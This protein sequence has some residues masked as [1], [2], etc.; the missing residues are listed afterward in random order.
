M[1]RWAG[2]A[3]FG[4]IGDNLVAGAPLYILKKLGYMTEM[5]TSE[6]N[7]VVFINN[8]HID[9]LSVH[10]TEKDLPQNDMLA[11]QKWFAGRERTFDLFAHLSHSMEGRHALF[12][13]FT[14]FYWSD[15]YRRKLCAGSYLE[16][17]CDIL[18]VPY[19]FDRLFYP[20]DDEMERA[21]R[22]K[23]TVGGKFVGW[24]IS[25]S[26]I[27]KVYP[28]CAMV[29]CRILKEL[30]IP[31]IMF[32]AG[33]KEK[34]IAY[35]IQ[36]HVKLQNS[37]LDGLH[38]ALSGDAKSVGDDFSW[39]LRRSLTMG[40]VADI[41]VSPDTGPAWGVAFEPIPKVIMVSH[42][43]VENITKHWV[44]TTTLHADQT[45][46]PCWPCHKLHN[47]P[48]TCRPN[49]ENNGAACI[50]DISVEKLFD[51][52]SGKLTEKE[53]NVLQFARSA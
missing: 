36:E 48:D 10:K 11:W 44:N 3:R 6:P 23:E 7:H 17:A 45:R 41:Y 47:T 51:T 5:I 18:G 12:E 2:I 25:G 15:Q 20:T 13:Q 53:T 16:T 19:E 46:V 24:C 9:K 28:Y 4:G 49:A 38:L 8:P 26:R 50:S 27:D 14:S 39:P 32:G 35:A 29:I 34:S 37:K 40:C 1:K 33:E 21:L 31:V 43:S 42:A 52:I 22:T 30:Q